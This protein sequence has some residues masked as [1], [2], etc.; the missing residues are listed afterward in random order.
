VAFPVVAGTNT[1]TQ[2]SSTS[3][4][5]NL[6]AS[7]AA[8]DL[9]IIFFGYNNTADDVTTPSGWTQFFNDVNGIRFY[10][11]YKVADGGE[12]A[13]VTIS[14]STSGASRHASYRITGYQSVPEATTS[15]GASATPDPPNLTP[16]WGAADTLWLASTHCANSTTDLAAPT[17]YGSIVQ[18]AI[19]NSAQ[20]GVAQRNLNAAS[21]NPGTFTGAT[22]SL[23]VAATVGVRPTAGGAA[24]KAKYYKQRRAA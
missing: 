18:S 23:W 20:V 9:L 5:V 4:T 19:Q 10:G 24:A 22:N 7:I 6:P 11:F 2:A 16:S 3:H 14:S 15:T 17:N 8:G 1:S 13:T 12:G 21:D